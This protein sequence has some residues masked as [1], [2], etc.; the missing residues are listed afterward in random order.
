[1]AALSHNSFARTP[2]ADI[3]FDNVSDV[4]CVAKVAV[5]GGSRVLW[6]TVVASTFHTS[7]AGTPTISD[8]EFVGVV[9]V[10][11]FPAAVVHGGCGTPWPPHCSTSFVQ[12]R[13]PVNIIP[14][15]VDVCV[16]VWW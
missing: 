7:R 6:N 8:I 5:G 4:S 1:M 12:A 2:P 9:D 16:F 15:Y 13:R 3:C 11:Q 14:S 10:G